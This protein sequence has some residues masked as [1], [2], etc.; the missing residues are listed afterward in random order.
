MQGMPLNEDEAKLK[1]SG[2]D[3]VN[4]F[5]NPMIGVAVSEWEDAVE[6]KGKGV[7]VQCCVVVYPWMKR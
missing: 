2:K 5:C 3:I 1:Y 7:K 4:P 6:R